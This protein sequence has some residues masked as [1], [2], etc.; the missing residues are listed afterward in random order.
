MTLALLPLL[1]GLVWLMVGITTLPAFLRLLAGRATVLDARMFPITA[2]AVSQ[3]CFAGLAMIERA[4]PS[5]LAR[6][7]WLAGWLIGALAAGKFF[8]LWFTLRERT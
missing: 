6:A 4:P 1:G 5:G 8:V 3:L 2:M 7:L